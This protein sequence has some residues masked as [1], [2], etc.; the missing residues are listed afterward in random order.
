[1]A[2]I[3]GSEVRHK[4]SK[5]PRSGPNLSGGWVVMLLSGLIAAVL[6]LFVTQQASD[7]VAVAVLAKDVPAGQRMDSSF[8]TTAEVSADSAQLDRLV[9]Y[10][11]SDRYT[12]W[13]ASGPMKAG[14]LVL[15]SSLREPAASEGRRSM[16]VPVDK[17][18]A[19]NGELQA[20]DRVDVIDPATNDG[21]VARNVE[22]LNAVSTSGG[23]GGN[24]SY[25]V[26]LAVNDEQAVKI[27]K[28]VATGKFD[29]IRSTGSSTPAASNNSSSSSG[30]TTTTTT[31]KEQ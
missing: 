9:R 12:G 8:F 30:S 24:D 21:Y 28:A 18:H 19:A 20:G 29:L 6:F 5:A 27:S 16:S 7:K 2:E 22:V 3:T 1:M 10:Q 14:D 31:T 26:I 11:D 23:I 15:S 4:A 17:N 25:T 13:I